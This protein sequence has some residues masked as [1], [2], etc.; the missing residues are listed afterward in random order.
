MF[1]VLEEGCE[2]RFDC[3]PDG[4][5]GGCLGKEA[6]HIGLCSFGAGCIMGQI[7]YSVSPHTSLQRGYK[8]VG[9]GSDLVL[10]ADLVM[11]FVVRIVDRK[12]V[13]FAGSLDLGSWSSITL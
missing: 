12:C 7:D 2:C 6:F 13:Q 4:E 1:D 3:G 5:F 10:G 8:S 9:G 11:L